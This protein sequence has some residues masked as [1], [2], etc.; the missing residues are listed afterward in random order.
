VLLRRSRLGPLAVLIAA[1]L[2]GCS[3]SEAPGPPSPG[4]A[5]KAASVAPPTPPTVPPPVV[6]EYTYEVKGRR[7]PFQPLIK[8]KSATQVR[9]RPKTGL[10]SLEV[11]ELKLAGIVW[12]QRGF[13]ALV[14]APNGAGYV[15]RVNDIIGEDARVAK[16]TPEGITVEV[17]SFDP[18]MRQVPARLVELRLRKEE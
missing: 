18:A 13:Y 4:P 12:E 11:N 1:G 14:E 17:K 9:V 16:I 2:A 6:A 10:A 7:D 5:A 8:P 15:I 3:G